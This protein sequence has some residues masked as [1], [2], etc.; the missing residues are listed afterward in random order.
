MKIWSRL[1][2]L[3]IGVYDIM[4]DEIYLALTVVLFV[5]MGA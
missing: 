3:G 1:G 4:W 2:R 5:F